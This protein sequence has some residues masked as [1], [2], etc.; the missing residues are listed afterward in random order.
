MLT[1]PGAWRHLPFFSENFPS[2]ASVVANEERLV[3]PSSPQVFAALEASAP[4][5]VRVVILGQ[6]PY[7]TP[8]H[9]H[10][11]AFSVEPDVQPLPR[12]LA[13]KVESIACA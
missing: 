6:D 13:N 5:D 2:I 3:L 11:F 8:G 1:P 9:A 7:P 10:G 4:D 12:S